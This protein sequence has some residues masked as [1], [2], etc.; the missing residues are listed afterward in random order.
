MAN[1]R[2]FLRNSASHISQAGRQWLFELVNGV[3]LTLLNCVMILTMMN[4]H[5][6]TCTSNFLKHL[7]VVDAQRIKCKKES[8]RLRSE[9]ES[10]PHEKDELEIKYKEQ[11]NI[12]D[13]NYDSG[14]R[15]N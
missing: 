2:K 13:S 10:L 8:K 4:T 14:T 3:N 7:K 11:T 6:K 15:M 5:W 1:T 12:L 9:M